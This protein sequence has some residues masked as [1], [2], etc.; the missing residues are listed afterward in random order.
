MSL[1]KIDGDKCSACGNCEEICPDVFELGEDGFSH[2]INNDT[3]DL[4]ACIEAAVENCP[5]DAISIEEGEDE[6]PDA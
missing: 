2:V 6:N 5:E 3:E 1:V 4:Q